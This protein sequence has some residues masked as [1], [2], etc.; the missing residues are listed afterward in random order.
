MEK[1]KIFIIIGIILILC[2]GIFSAVLLKKSNNET[3]QEDITFSEYEMASIKAIADYKNKIKNPY[4]LEV[5]EIRVYK[6]NATD[7]IFDCKEIIENGKEERKLV[8]YSIGDGGNVQ[9]LVDTSK[10][11][12]TSS[13]FGEQ[14]LITI[15]NVVRDEW[16]TDT[17]Y[18]SIDKEKVLNNLD[19]ANNENNNSLKEVAS[20]DFSSLEQAISNKNLIN[21]VNEH[22]KI[23]K[24]NKNKEDTEK[25]ANLTKDLQVLKDERKAE[26]IQKVD[27]N[28]DDMTQ[29]TI[30]TLKGS[31]NL[32]NEDVNLIPML[33]QSSKDNLTFFGLQLGFVNESWIFF[34]SLIVNVDG[35]LTEISSNYYDKT[36]EVITGGV[37]ERCTLYT[38]KYSNFNNLVEKMINGNEIK[39]R[40]VGQAGKGNI[41][42]VVTPS[43]KEHLKIFYELSLCL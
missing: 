28:Y 40:F 26:L 36:K 39:I 10:A 8:E 37:F 15:A 41:D 32:F 31:D 35:D 13:N 4:S 24:L 7:I 19:K 17:D 9:Y 43:E 34:E 27:G 42:H 38:E 21:A 11:G 30:Y 25:F 22:T 18:T 14:M 12:Q 33:V 3:K 16:D 20:V 2:I 1:K 29:D 5:F 6:K 23:T